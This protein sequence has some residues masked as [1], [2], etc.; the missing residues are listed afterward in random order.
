ML[1]L[2][3]LHKNIPYKNKLTPYSL[4][5]TM[6]EE[7][8]PDILFHWHRDME[9]IYVHE[10]EAQF[11]ID[12]DYFNSEKGDIILIRPNALH[13]IHP[14]GKTYHFMDAINVHLDLLG[15]STVDYASIHY[16]QPLYNGELDF[17]RVIKPHQTGYASIRQ[18][19]IEAMECGYQH[20]TFFELE[21]KSK[22]LALLHLLFKHGYV[23]PKTQSSDGYRK[24]EK[25]RTII[26]Y[27]NAHY[28]EELTIDHLAQIAGYSPTHFMNF[29]KKHLGVSC[30][31]YLIHYRLKQ[32]TE[33]LQHS[34]L[35]VLEIAGES[36][37]TN[38]SNFNRQFKKVYQM[39]PSQYRKKM[40]S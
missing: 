26:D 34:T 27:M 3:Q 29:F 12:Y 35:S 16:L 18:L 33:L 5:R 19:L 39:T 25:I 32:A 11:H 9:I 14:I 22:L 23:A 24:E 36:G 6:M 8:Q 17:A 7:G 4:T 20:E 30:M 28:Q 38:L 15:Y 31:D 13:S 2:G 40:K 1:D 21:L 37:F 10:G